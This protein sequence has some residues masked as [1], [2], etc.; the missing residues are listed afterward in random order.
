METSH[1]FEAEDL[2]GLLPTTPLHHQNLFPPKTKD[3]RDVINMF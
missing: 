3:E 2:A 1:V